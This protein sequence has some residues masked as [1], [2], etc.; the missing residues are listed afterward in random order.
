MTLGVA[1]RVILDG[2]KDLTFP[3]FPTHI[4]YIMTE[5]IKNAARATVEFHGANKS[6]NEL[7]PIRVT[8]ASGREDVT[9]RVSGQGGGIPRSKIKNIWKYSYT[10]A[11]EPT[12]LAGYG[13]GLPLSRLYARYFGGDLKLLSMDGWGSDVYLTLHRLGTY[14]ESIANYDPEEVN[15]RIRVFIAKNEGGKKLIEP[16]VKTASGSR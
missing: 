11:A 3:Y 10:T 9:L 6:E 12:G 15:H 16:L 1:P 14:Q 2:H 13:F 7:P 4:H 5:V 8:V